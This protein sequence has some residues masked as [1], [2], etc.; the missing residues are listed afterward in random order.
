MFSPGS[1]R[2]TK[3]DTRKI[4]DDAKSYAPRYACL[5][6]VSSASGRPDAFLVSDP[7]IFNSRYHVDTPLPSFQQV[8][9]SANVM[10]PQLAPRDGIS[11]I[12]VEEKLGVKDEEFVRFHEISVR[13]GEIA[14]ELGPN[15][16]AGLKI[17]CNL[18]EEW[19]KRLT[20]VCQRCLISRVWSA[21]AP[22]NR[23]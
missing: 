11:F 9:T 21:E 14:L 2:L 23:H 16:Q 5:M 22:V 8:I 3:A 13:H 1:N 19:A 12:F 7:D 10:G 20:Q 17:R 15:G 4:L 18:G 6:E